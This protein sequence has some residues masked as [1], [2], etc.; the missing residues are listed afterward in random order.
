[1]DIYRE[2][3]TENEDKLKEFFNKPKALQ[4][5]LVIGNNIPVCT[6][7]DV[8]VTDKYAVIECGRI[9]P[10][11]GLHGV[12]PQTRVDFK[13]V[14]SAAKKRCPSTSGI[15]KSTIKSILM[16]CPNKYCFVKDIPEY[17]LSGSIVKDILY[18]KITNPH[19]AIAKYGKKMG[20]KNL[21]KTVF[22]IAGKLGISPMIIMTVLDINQLQS[23]YNAIV[24]R[25]DHSYDFTQTF[26]DMLE[27][28][29]ALEEKV[30]LLWS[31]NKMGK[32]HTEWSRQLM[33]LDLDNKETVP[34]WSD[35]IV[36][37]LEQQGLELLNT[38]QMV[39]EEG[40]MMNNCVYTNYW[41]R[42]KSKKTLALG[43]EFP[44]GHA[45]LGLSLNTKRKGLDS[46]PYHTY[47]FE[48]CYHKYNK[49]LS[50]KEGQWLLLKL[51]EIEKTLEKMAST[52][53]CE[54]L[55][56]LDTHAPAMVADIPW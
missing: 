29:Y 54:K 39:F 30:N 35:D 47:V 8:V 26:K 42:I 6:Y 1:M 10:T 45:T 13:W 28:A 37:E 18:G 48:Q 33:K 2:H 40:Y 49:N 15:A 11:R 5:Y 32:V 16:D 21:N 25:I 20:I 43:I 7:R 19:D 41:S 52:A 22:D 23:C 12:F 31:D 51:V 4:R 56:Q 36:E 9:V 38:E 14:Y 55:V 34:I 27:Q 17:V 44:G 50:A 46:K 53:V 24:D 3:I